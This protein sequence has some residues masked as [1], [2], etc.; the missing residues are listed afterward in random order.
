MYCGTFEPCTFFRRD[1]HRARRVGVVV[2]VRAFG[3]L[4]GAL[5]RV[6]D[7]VPVVVVVAVLSFVV[8]AVSV[9]VPCVLSV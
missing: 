9:R 7:V 8:L 5:M 2:R 3:V 6:W 4:G 1:S